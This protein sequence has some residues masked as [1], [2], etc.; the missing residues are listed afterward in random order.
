MRAQYVDSVSRSDI[1][2]VLV[3]LLVLQLFP[4]RQYHDADAG[5]SLNSHEM[6]PKFRPSGGFCKRLY[7]KPFRL[8]VATAEIV[9][10]VLVLVPA[11]RVVGAALSLAIMSGAIFFHV[12]SPLGIDPYKDGGYLFKEACTVWVSSA[13]ILIIYRR[14]AIAMLQQVAKLGGW[15]TRPE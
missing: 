11:T 3:A 7:E 1:A 13:F 12:V 8:S 9:A 6:T 5:V 2:R 10:S 4:N 15:H 14:E